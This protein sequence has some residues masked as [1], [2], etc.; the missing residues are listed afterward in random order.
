[1]TQEESAGASTL[2]RDKIGYLAGET[3]ARF[4][5]TYVLTCVAVLIAVFVIN[6]MGNADDLY[7]NPYRPANSDRAWKTRR[8]E[9]LVQTGHLPRV[10]ILGSSRM[11]QMCPTYIEAITHKSTFNYAVTGGNSLDC[12]LQLRLVLRLGVR[13]ELVILNVDENMLISDVGIGQL[14]VAGHGG[15]F[16]EVPNREQLSIVGGILQG[17]SF[18]STVR[19]LEALLDG[20]Q[21]LSKDE[22]LLRRRGSLFLENGYLIHHAT[23]ARCTGKYDLAKT[24][25]AEVDDRERLDRDSIQNEERPSFRPTALEY[26]R[27]VL[28]LAATVGSEVRVIVTP[29]HPSVKNTV[30]GRDREYLLGNLRTFLENESELKHF[31][32][33]EF[34]DL[35]T[36]GGDP[37]EFWD[38]THQTPVNMRRMANAVFGIRPDAIVWPSSSDCE[39]VRE[40]GLP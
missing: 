22:Q 2:G 19:N 36:F 33:F 34:S 24:I 29:E 26:L 1:M 25:Q 10:L 31:S 8:L 17:I 5:I 39:V 38:G 35:S 28:D 4:T 9:Q 20:W 13:P 7:P 11:Q 12:L 23:A 27:N 40:L 37:N 16:C 21:P 3:S 18:E 30:L 6:I 32:F 15:L 14:R